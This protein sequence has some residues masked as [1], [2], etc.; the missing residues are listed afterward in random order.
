MASFVPWTACGPGRFR[1]KGETDQLILGGGG[2]PACWVVLG[3]F[4]T[5]DQ[6]PVFLR[7]LLV[8]CDK[9]NGRISCSQNLQVFSSGKLFIGTLFS[10]L[11]LVGGIFI[12]KTRARNTTVNE[13][14]IRL[15]LRCELN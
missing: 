4:V 2:R 9:L 14:E 12:C 8:S 6:N 7:R 13:V 11:G 3:K 1:G 5:L 15:R 10:L